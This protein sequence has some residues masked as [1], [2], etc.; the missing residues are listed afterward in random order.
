MSK[1]PIFI[2]GGHHNS[3]LVIA[4][5]L[6]RLGYRV[7]WLGH[8]FSIRGDKNLS[9]EY[10]EVTQNSI[11]FYQLRTGKIYKKFN[12]LEYLLV[13]FGF[14]QSLIYLLL[15]RPQL[16]ISFGGYLA[17][18]VVFAAWLLH[19]PSVTHEQT[20]VTG[21]ANRAIT[22]FVR[23]ILLTHKASQP[24]FP[25]QKTAIVG[26]PLRSDLLTS[27]RYKS[28]KT[29]ILYITCG[30]QGSHII[31]Q[32][33]FPLIPKLV[34]HFRVVHQTGSYSHFQDRDK[35]RRLKAS[36]P[37]RLRSRYLHAT[38]FFGSD[39]VRY[40]KT[41]RIVVSRSGAHTTYE[42]LLL[43]KRSILIPIPWVSHHEQQK[44]AELL[45]RQGN[46]VIIPQDQ[47]TPELLYEKITTLDHQKLKKSKT[48]PII[49]DSTQRFLAQI[50]PFLK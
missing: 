13:I 33:V 28:P 26:L 10:Q 36:L 19:I 40:L 39:A 38:Y 42:L 35:A 24:N 22:P 23:R 18:P 11:P 43:N 44:N 6:K 14:F 8:K 16:V 17:V 4:L 5:E 3:A 2:T 45:V 21:W 15:N 46:S 49:T 7:I 32:A 37:P 48:T 25:K 1:R 41:S 29:P 50:K 31:N 12:P 9:A 47:L 34:K 30:K 20:V 27:R